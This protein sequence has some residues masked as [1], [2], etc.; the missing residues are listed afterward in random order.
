MQNKPLKERIPGQAYFRKIIELSEENNWSIYLLGGKE[1][2]VQATKENLQK[3]YPKAN[4]VGVHNGYF[5]KEEE[6]EIIKEI[7]E[8]QPN[9]LFVAFGAPKQELW[10]AKHKEELKVDIACRTTEG[11]LIMSQEE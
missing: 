11:L 10:I 4:F 2:V 5:D 1:E 9:I 8:K 7:N 3:K 6:K